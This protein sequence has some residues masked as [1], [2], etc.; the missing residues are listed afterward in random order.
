M[1][2]STTALGA[3][4]LVASTF[5]QP[6][7]HG[8]GHVHRNVHLDKRDQV[9]MT[10]WVT[11]WVT[12]I[13]TVD[14]NGQQATPGIFKTASLSSSSSTST[15]EESTTISLDETSSEEPTSTEEPSTSTEEPEPETTEEPEQPTTT[16]TTSEPEPEPTTTEKPVTVAKVTPEPEPE[17][18]PTTSSAPPVDNSSEDTSNAVG[19]SSETFNPAHSGF[20]TYYLNG[21]G[22]CGWDDSGRNPSGSESDPMIVAVSY[23]VYFAGLPN[24]NNMEL[25]GA[26][27]KMMSPDN[28]NVS[29]YGTIRDACRA[30]TTAGDLDVNIAGMQ[31]FY[32]GGQAVQVGKGS[33]QWEIVG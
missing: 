14:E 2:S 15:K 20:I 1:K 18:E 28:P 21:L 31:A 17:P 24:P 7:N 26:K 10:E 4:L 25:C 23:D 27:I 9:T 12:E 30:C 6:H 8:H 5:A 19:D 22:A 11:S 3:A 29:A 32:P 13:V 16:S 33:I